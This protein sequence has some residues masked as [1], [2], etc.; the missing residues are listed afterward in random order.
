MFREDLQGIL[1]VKKKNK[2]QNDDTKSLYDDSIIT[3]R[4]KLRKSTTNTGQHPQ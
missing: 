2:K 4:S 1:K 3:I